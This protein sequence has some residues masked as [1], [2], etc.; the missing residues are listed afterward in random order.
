MKK[1]LFGVLLVLVALGL[2]A[3]S[4]LAA[5][6]KTSWDVTFEV[7][8]GSSVATTV[9]MPGKLDST[10][11]ISWDIVS[12]DASASAL[13]KHLTAKKY[14]GSFVTASAVEVGSA[15]STISLAIS[16]NEDFDK[17]QADV[18]SFDTKIFV[19]APQ[20]YS[21]VTFVSA[22]TIPS[23][24]AAI[25]A[26][27]FTK[28]SLSSTGGAVNDIFGAKAPYLS[29]DRKTLTL[30]KIDQDVDVYVFLKPGSDKSGEP[31]TNSIVVKIPLKYVFTA[32]GDTGDISL[33]N[34]VDQAD[35]K[36]VSST[37]ASGQR[38][39]LYTLM[40]DWGYNTAEDSNDDVEK[41]IE[42]VEDAKFEAEYTGTALEE[43]CKM[44]YSD[45]TPSLEEE[46]QKVVAA[47]APLTVEEDEAD[48][49]YVFQTKL[50]GLKKGQSLSVYAYKAGL[51]NTLMDL[52]AIE[53]NISKAELVDTNSAKPLS[54]N[55][56][57]ANDQ[58]VTFGIEFAD[59]GDYILYL[60]A[61]ETEEEEEPTA[62]PSETPA[63]STPSTSTPTT[64]TPSTS[65]PTTTTPK[66]GSSSSGCDMGLV[67]GL[68]VLLA[69]LLPLRKVRK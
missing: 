8:V 10:D 57:T 51:P 29:T 4:A 49:L 67:S 22:D 48:K 16:Y 40:K 53:S 69:A 28:S 13:E 30:G 58:K 32:G 33:I 24:E 12:K 25:T 1:R 44:F 14:K 20:Y 11:M 65:T 52:S 41:V 55:T 54:D 56:L 46:G 68:A 45:V 47:F 3:S 27:H 23:T 42:C 60:T 15:G 7:K 19:S 61:E 35:R 43:F 2:M 26:G 21:S 34:P 9:K 17:D 6:P 36:I 31:H 5:S 64:S 39:S 38:P 18:A 59:A 37:Y 62:T 50:F 63:T 66:S